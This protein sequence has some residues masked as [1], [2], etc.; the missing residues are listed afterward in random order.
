MKSANVKLDVA[1]YAAVLFALSKSVEGATRAEELLMQMRSEAASGQYGASLIPTLFCYNALIYAW[2]YSGDP[3]AW[4]RCEVVFD[5]LQAAYEN[6]GWDPQLR[7]DASSYSLLI[8]SLLQSNLPNAGQRAEAI[9]DRMEDRAA[10]GQCEQPN[11]KVFTSVMKVYWKC[12]DSPDAARKIELIMSRMRQAYRAGNAAAKPDANATTVLLHAWA[13]SN[14]PNKA[15]KC[16]SIIEEM[17][18]AYENGQVDMQPTAYSF[19][20]VLN[21]CA[22]TNVHDK[23]I[24]DRAVKVALM[25]INE[26]DNKDRIRGGLNE[27]T[28]RNM[29]QVI[30]RQIDDLKERKTIASVIFERC[31]Q[32]GYVG[33]WTIRLLKENVPE[34]Y[35]KLLFDGSKKLKLPSLWTRRVNKDR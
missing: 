33:P 32:E 6:S 23:A 2:C 9:L 7:P 27:Y 26:L 11:V 20:A 4:E 10:K 30:A 12:D 15:S 16:W 8:E 29:F 14:D 1:S 13:K 5:Q 24:K 17:R 28:F 34:L 35:R 31:C 22:F 25:A 21:A 19:S 18:A 3:R